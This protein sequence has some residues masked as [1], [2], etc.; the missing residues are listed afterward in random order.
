MESALICF[1]LIASADPPAEGALGREFFE[2][3]VNAA[4]KGSWEDARAAFARAYELTRHPSAIFNRAGAEPKL[5]QMLQAAA[6]YR[7]YLA[8]TAGGTDA[9]RE[10]AEQALESL[11]ARIPRITVQIEGLEPGDAIELD[12]KPFGSDRSEL[13]PGDHVLAVRREGRELARTRFSVSEGETREVRLSLARE[14]PKLS[15]PVVAETEPEP[16]VESST[17]PYWTIGAGAALVG[18]AAVLWILAVDQK[19]RLDGNAGAS[20]EE[21]VREIRSA[22]RKIIAADVLVVA[23]G[24]ALGAGI[25]WALFFNEGAPDEGVAVGPS[26]LSLSF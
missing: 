26:G 13:D 14:E 9:N 20:Y 16:A 25:I 8:L 24:L 2:L 1:L 11:G 7:E 17:L 15:E 12:G 5:G 23:G 21:Q 6:S 10:L 4:K 22:N 19:S 18:T 3:G